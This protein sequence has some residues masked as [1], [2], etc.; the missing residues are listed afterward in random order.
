MV[1]VQL[2]S[3]SIRYRAGGFVASLLTL[4]PLSGVTEAMALCAGQGTGPAARNPTRRAD[5][6]HIGRGL[7]GPTS[8]LVTRR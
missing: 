7:P 4:A 8:P 5:R 6:R 3:R 1:L 2:A